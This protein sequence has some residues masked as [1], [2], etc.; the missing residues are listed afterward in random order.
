MELKKL[1]INDHIKILIVEDNPNDAKLIDYHI[2]RVVT[3]PEILCVETFEDFVTALD[4]FEPE[5]ILSDY[6]MNGFDGMEVL[7]H[8]TENSTVSSFV[9]ITGTINN[10]ELAAQTILS[11]ATG[12]ILKKN[13]NI[14]HT[15]LLPYFEQLL[16][17]RVKNKQSNHEEIL[18]KVRVFIK[19][20]DKDNQVHI[21]SYN[22]IKDA[23][24]KIKLKQNDA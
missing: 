17:S 14:L 12:Y 13:I 1:M 16:A 5:I 15:K 19:N 4:T 6:R 21:D 3:E 7:K 24:D 20:A 23:L 8:T 11:G 9:F 22:Q 10:E 2:K 18:E